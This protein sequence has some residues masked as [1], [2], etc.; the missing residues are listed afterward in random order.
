MEASPRLAV[1][2]QAEMDARTSR[3]VQQVASRTP[4]LRAPTQ[5][6]RARTDA[7]G[8]D[9]DDRAVSFASMTADASKGDSKGG[10]L[11]QEGKVAAPKEARGLPPVPPIQLGRESAYGPPGGNSPG[12]V[13]G[14]SPADTTPRLPVISSGR[15]SATSAASD[16]ARWAPP[17][18]VYV[19]DA[20]G[21]A[22]EKEYDDDDD[23]R[24]GAASGAATAVMVSPAEM[25][26]HGLTADPEKS[27]S[28]IRSWSRRG[29]GSME[30]LL[31][32]MQEVVSVV[33]LSLQALSSRAARAVRVAL[34]QSH[35]ASKQLVDSIAKLL[36]RDESYRKERSDAAVAMLSTKMEL[37]RLHQG[38]AGPSATSVGHAQRHAGLEAALIDE[39]LDG[40]DGV[41][42]AMHALTKRMIDSQERWE[43]KKAKIEEARAKDFAHTVTA[44]KATLEA[45]KGE[46]LR[47]G[48]QAPSAGGHVAYSFGNRGSSVINRALAQQRLPKNH[49]VAHAPNAPPPRRDPNANPLAEAAAAARLGAASA[50]VGT[51]QPSP[52]AVGAPTPLGGAQHGAIRGAEGAVGATPSPRTGTR[53]ITMPTGSGDAAP[54][55]PP[56]K[57]P[58]A[59]PGPLSSRKAGAGTLLSPHAPHASPSPTYTSPPPMGAHAPPTSRRDSLQH[60]SLRADAVTE[61]ASMVAA[62]EV[63]PQQQPH[64]SVARLGDA[65]GHSHILFASPLA[66]D[67]FRKRFTQ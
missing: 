55:A 64:S 60:D 2:Q 58:T 8:D 3:L 50:L 12:A 20:A 21:F 4:D 52:R 38:L 62:G 14:G 51:I 35:A 6:S 27:L 63:Q 1:R 28:A 24:G 57:A 29:D 48:G 13:S 59:A 15:P 25:L 36:A 49:Y 56:I 40:N 43:A 33:G 18:S 7:A 16:H 46:G 66:G 65:G 41:T 30:E 5:A 42:K 53:L 23:E 26:A 10:A 67:A 17:P 45:A 39:S 47:G 31:P 54:T 44:L 32:A 11:S 34:E 22:H 19:G 9:R 37:L 61:A